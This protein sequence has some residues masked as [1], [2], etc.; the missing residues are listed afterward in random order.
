MSDI[1]KWAALVVGFIA[2]IAVI[3][4]L[5]VFVYMEIPVLAE[6]IGTIVEVC[7]VG[8]TFGRG[9]INNLFFERGRY[10]LSELMNYLFLKFFITLGI[11]I[12]AWAYH[13]IFK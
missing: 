6:A 2:V 9:L 4:A 3:M 13:F 1:A 12:T 8:L 5:P 7:S 11:K 10:I